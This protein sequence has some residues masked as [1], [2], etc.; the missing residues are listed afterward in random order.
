MGLR[1]QLRSAQKNNYALN[2]GHRPFSDTPLGA[3][4]LR[5]RARLMEQRRANDLRLNGPKVSLMQK[6]TATAQ[7][8]IEAVKST[9]T[10]VAEATN[11]VTGVSDVIEVAAEKPKRVRKPKAEAPAVA[12]A[13]EPVMEKKPRK[14]GV[15]KKATEGV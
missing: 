15:R 2:T 11:A 6:I 4:Q 13:E 10:D 8:A 3:G 14:V 1:K 12:V 5:A 9:L 7:A